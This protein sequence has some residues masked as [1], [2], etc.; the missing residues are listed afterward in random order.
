MI[1]KGIVEIYQ[2]DHPQPIQL[3][4]GEIIG[5]ISFI[6]GRPYSADCVAKTNVELMLLTTHE[7]KSIQKQVPEF[8]QR[9]KNL[10]AERLDE[11]KKFSEQENMEKQRWASLAIDAIHHGT[12][13]PSREEMG[14]RHA[15]HKNAAFV[16]EVIKIQLSNTSECSGREAFQFLETCRTIRAHLFCFIETKTC[17]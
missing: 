14:S 3:G 9:L 5:E 12:T 16:K 13:I 1:R 4:H 10:A 15:E 11:N 2:Q 6:A 7:F 17:N 8:E